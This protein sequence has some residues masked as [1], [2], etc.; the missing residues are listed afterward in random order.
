M[1]VT[2][3]SAAFADKNADDGKTVTFSGYSL[4]DT[5]A[6]NYTLS[7]QPASVT[8]N[9]TKASLTV[10][11][12]PHTINYG[13]EPAGGGIAYSGFV[14][15]ETSSVLGGALTYDYNYSQYGDVGGYTI[16]PSGLTSDNYEISFVAGTL[17]VEQKEVGLTWSTTPLTFN[18]SA[19][20][21][22]AS[23]TELVNGDTVSVTVTGAQTDAETGYTATA[24]ELTGAKAGNYKLPDLNTTTFSIGKAGAQTL[25]D[26]TQNKSYQITEVTASV[27]GKMSANAGTLSYAKGE[28]GKTGS[29]TISNWSVDSSTGAVAATISGGAKNDTITLPVII[30]STNYADSTVNV[31]VTLVD[32]T[33]AAVTI[34]GDDTKTYGDT[35]FSL[36]AQ[37]ADIG[38][39]TGVWSWTSSNEDVATITDEG[40]VTIISAGTATITA[41]YESDTTIGSAT[42][43]LT[44][45]PKSVAIPTAATGLKWTG[46]ELTGVAAGTGYTVTGEKETDVGSYT[47][48][49]T[50]TST[51][52]YIWSDGTTEAKEISWSI[53]KANGPAAPIGLSGIPPTSTGGSDGKIKGVT[54]RMEYSTK[55]DFS[56]ATPCSGSEITGLSAGTYY[57]RVKETTTSEA[58]AYATVTIAAKSSGGSGGTGG[59]GGGTTPSKPDDPTPDPTPGTETYTIPVTNDT[60]VPVDTKIT[61]GNAVVSEITAKDI[62]KITGS[63]SGEGKTADTITIDLSG[64]KQNVDSVELTKGTVEALTKA[65][66]DTSNDVE[67]VTIRMTD[68]TVELDASALEAIAKQSGG[69]TAK[70][71]VD[72]GYEKSALNKKQQEAIGDYKEAVIFEAYLESDGTKIHDLN[73]GTA[74]VSM[75]YDLP[76]GLSSQSVRMLYLDPTGNVERLLTTY[77]DGW[78][79]GILTHCSEYAIVYDESGTADDQGAVEMHRLYNPNSGEHFYTGNI[80]EKDHL[81][82]VGW[83]YEGV[84]WTSPESSEIPVYRLYNPNAGDHHYTTDVAERDYLIEVGWSDEGIGWYSE[85][86]KAVPVYRLYNPNALLAGAHH[87]TV[88]VK[89]RD[90][91]NELG[92][93]DEGIGWYGL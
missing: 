74:K 45:N 54:D 57:V 60:S 78:A 52:N 90:Y 80:A 26:I 15:G 77:E 93:R 10:T 42:L 86:S 38:T 24:S 50:L 2:A 89:E 58:G 25:S 19:Q 79:T 49:A 64:A 6:G 37:A 21:P 39:G 17:T 28:A 83:S 85:E 75:Q 27:A 88:D 18:G 82:E 68:A 8:A 9:I 1:T 55:A 36:S 12:K 70:L 31:K 35:G 41:S 11:A 84:A 29:V 44:V 3:G 66:A 40:T 16:T 14:D 53:G 63:T 67:T 23:A 30:S 87:F 56:T 34:A 65:L 62:E 32:K 5:D 81:I 61:D 7:A 51:T 91:L 46:S 92:W 71:S 22:T 43:L 69:K 76:E 47:A 72:K 73:G 48:T 20:A 33:E 4:S 59:G 13:D